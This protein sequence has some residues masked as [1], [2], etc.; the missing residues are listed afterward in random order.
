MYW[1][2]V[3]RLLRYQE[4]SDIPESHSGA[5]DFGSIGW[6]YIKKRFDTKVT[7]MKFI[8]LRRIFVMD[9]RVLVV[10]SSKSNNSQKRRPRIRLSGFW[11]NEIGFEYDN[12]VSAEYGT[13]SIVLKLQGKGTETYSKV[14]KGLLKN[15][16][17][18]LQVNHEFKNKK[19]TIHLD[20][21]GF[22][23]EDYGFKIG[24]VIVVKS[25]YGVINIRVLDL[26]KL[27]K[28]TI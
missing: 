4:Y 14:V 22:W 11:L 20:L 19:Q 15:K 9:T 17:G 8:H 1:L 2:Y 24:S 21:K 7:N 16:S 12:L 3:L 10:G 27:D 13:G 28:A 5:V 23:M 25:E 26:D 18:L 6:A